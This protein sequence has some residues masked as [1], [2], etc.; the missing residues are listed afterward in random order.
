MIGSDSKEHRYRSGMPCLRVLVV[1]FLCS[2]YALWVGNNGSSSNTNNGL[3]RFNSN[4]T[5]GSN[6]NASRLIVGGWS[7]AVLCRKTNQSNYIHTIYAQALH[8]S[9][10][11]KISAMKTGVSRSTLESPCKT[12]R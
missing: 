2:V 9:H 5:P 10:S 7:K 11:V 3:F 6:N 4:N 1:G 12:K 8:S